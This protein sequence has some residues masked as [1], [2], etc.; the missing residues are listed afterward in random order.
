MEKPETYYRDHWLAIDAER[1]EVYDKMFRWRPEM[2]VLLAPAGLADGQSVLDYG[3]GPGWMAIELAKRVGARGQVH[4][5]DVNDAFLARAREHAAE[6][7][8]RERMSFHLLTGDRLPLGDASLDRVVSKNVFEYLENVH[9]TLAEMRR[10]LRPGGRLHVI[11]SDW[12]MLAVEPLGEK[13]I[14]ELFAAA[15]PAYKTPLIGRKL[16]GALREAGFRDLRVQILASAD[17]KGHFAPIV[18]NMASYAR[19]SGRMQASTVDRMLDEVQASIEN[20]TY[21]LVLP[22]FLVT[23]SA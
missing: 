17:T 18:F 12:G 23:G 10:V 15:S 9:A 19:A 3:C 22:Q 2:D 1:F 5:A 20:G 14:A 7:G 13:S 21:L 11:D 8:V 6:Q 4:A 16:Y